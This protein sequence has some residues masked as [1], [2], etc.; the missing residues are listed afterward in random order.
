MTLRFSLSIFCASLLTAGAQNDLLPLKDKAAL[1]EEKQKNKSARDRLPVG[2]V[3]ADFSAPRFTKDRKRLSLLT[4]RQMVVESTDELNGD[5]IKVWMFD[6]E[7]TIRS[8][9]TIDSAEYHL[10]DEILVGKGEIIARDQKDEFY[11]QSQ[12][13]II[14]LKSSQALL[15]GTA[16][17]MFLIPEQT[18]K[19][20]ITMNL[21]ST[22]PFIAAIQLLAAAPPPEIT[23]E[24]L[25]EFERLV[26]P[27]ML[28]EFEG[29]EL[30]EE[31]VGKNQDLERRM[32]EF[33]TSS[34]KYNLL[35]QAS[36][37]PAEEEDPLADLFKPHPDRIFIRSSDGIYFDGTNFELVYRGNIK[38]EGKGV[39]M[40]CDKDLKVLFDPPV[41]KEE[42]AEANKEDTDKPEKPAPEKENTEPE[43]EEEDDNPLSGLGGVGELK[44]LTATGNLRISGERNGEQFHLGGDRAVYDKAKNQI[45]IR[46]DRLGCKMGENGFRSINKN[47]YAVINIGPDNQ[48]KDIQMS[49]GDWVT[50]VTAPENE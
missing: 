21:N 47:A 38:L 7:E 22:L 41:E 46:G 49:R 33:L 35:L 11:A 27:R 45:I 29:P 1:E 32:A 30:M 17:T 14:N 28:P 8:I 18:K 5:G 16:H 19:E 48:I 12:G 25:I 36:A 6:K 3:L 24:E 23:A 40:T 43:K 4:A 39:K 31:A 44:Q 34:E 10:D 2:A 37:P 9:T 20:P 42:T 15:T 26:A 13:G 50:V